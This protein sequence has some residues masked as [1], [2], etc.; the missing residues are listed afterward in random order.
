MDV[1]SLIKILCYGDSNTWGR[2]PDRSGRFDDR[3]R[4]T[5]QLQESLGSSY[6]VIEEG[7]EGRSTDQDFGRPARNGKKNL[8]DVIGKYHHVEVVL[9]MLGTVDILNGRSPQETA[10]ALGDLAK[11]IKGLAVNDK[12]DPPKI[13][14]VS[15]VFIDDTTKLFK[16]LYKPSADNNIQNNSRLL[17]AEL[18]KVAQEQGCFYTDVSKIAI[19]GEDGVHIDRPSQDKLAGLMFNIVK[20]LTETNGESC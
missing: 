15:P 6:M 7:L 12:G 8:K 11:S 20:A 3:V 17:G 4:W 14:V 2:L 13:V 10:V 16:E 5:G 19:V 9:L 18:N 1:N